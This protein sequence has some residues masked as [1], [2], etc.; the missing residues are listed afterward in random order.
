MSKHISIG[1][2]AISYNEEE[3][4][5]GFLE[6]LLPWVDEV[7]IVDD[8][9]SDST[10][11]IAESAGAKVKFIESPRG[12]GEY[13]SHQRNK[14]ID[15]A[16][17]DWLI[18]MDIDERV[19]DPLVDEMVQAI[20]DEKFLAYRYRRENYFL[21]RPMKGGGWQDW[22]QIHL[23]KRECLRFGGMFHE[24]VIL[25]PDDSSKVGQLHSKM[26]HLNDAS[27]AERLRKSSTYLD[28]VVAKILE[29]GKRIGFFS[30]GMSFVK[31]FIKKYFWKLGF[32]DGTPG[33]ISAFHSATAMF[34]AYAVVWEKQNGIDRK[35]IEDQLR[36]DRESRA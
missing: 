17:S 28:E 20:K 21:H 33:L 25:D 26:I 35:A 30:I 36:S 5:P 3:D 10:R 27:F 8:G 1:V 31:E 22:N 7:V 4:L 19:P 16:E 18:H 15:A 2:V 11:K 13:Y 14:G 34:R 6:N 9:S 29:T 23:A 12:E 24:N 32:R